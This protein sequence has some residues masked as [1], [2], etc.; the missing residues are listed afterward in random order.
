M[1]GNYPLNIETTYFLTILNLAIKIL[2]MKREEKQYKLFTLSFPFHVKV[3]TG[4]MF[5]WGHGEQII[6]EHQYIIT[7]FLVLN[8]N[9]VLS[10]Q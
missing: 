4:M 1:Q 6:I 10:L 8:I 3:I 2:T 9:D 5:M 7:H